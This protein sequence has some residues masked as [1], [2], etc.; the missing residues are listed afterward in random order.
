MI[1]AWSSE[2]WSLL[3]AAAALALSIGNIV[4]G[5]VHRWRTTRRAAVEVRLEQFTDVRISDAFQRGVI[6]TKDSEWRLVLHNHGPAAAENVNLVVDGWD[7]KRAARYFDRAE[8]LPVPVLHAGQTFPIALTLS[9]GDGLP[10]RVSLTW[11]DKRGD[12]KVDVFVS[13]MRLA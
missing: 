9:L 13:P 7:A 10:K 6:S 11:R 3:I 4:A 1:A 2:T 8:L 5:V 12:Q